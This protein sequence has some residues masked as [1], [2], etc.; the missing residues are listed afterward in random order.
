MTR[1]EAT[2]LRNTTHGMSKRPEYSNWKD[3][4]KRCFNPEN[5]RYK[6][7]AE[8]GISVHPDFVDNFPAFLAE[9]GHKPEGNGWSVG[10]VN[11]NA[12]YTYG[13]IRWE[14]AEQ[15]ARNHSKQRNN[16][17]GVTGVKVRTRVIA[18]NFYTSVTAKWTDINGKSHTKDFSADKYG[19]DTAFEMAVKYRQA[20]IEEL[21]LLG[22]GYGDSHGSDK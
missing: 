20:R 3:M 5:K 22:A 2:S 10:R 15:Q 8:R 19:Y 14:R 7:Y 17:S 4:K 11:N 16:S 13:N 9:I 21:N 18:G 1:S 6:D 12:W